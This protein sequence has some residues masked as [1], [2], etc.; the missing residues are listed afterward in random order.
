MHLTLRDDPL[1]LEGTQAVICRIKNL[2]NNAYPGFA[3]LR[4]RDRT[5]AAKVELLEEG[6]GSIVA[7]KFIRS[8]LQAATGDPI[9]VDFTDLSAAHSVDIA[10]PAQYRRDALADLIRDS[11][12]GK[13]LCV[14]QLLPVFT[15]P[16]TGD[17]Q[18]G[19]VRSIEPGPIAVVTPATELTL[20]VGSV[21]GPGVTYKNIGGLSREIEQIRE[22]VEFPFR[23][24]DIFQSLGITPS[25]G[26]ILFG[27]PGA[28]K[29][30][31]AK[32]LAHEVGASIFTIQG[33]EIISGWY[34]GSEQNLR[35]VFEQAREQA[36]AIIMIDEIDSVAPRRDKTRG[37]VEHRV[38]ATLLTLMDGMRDLSRVVV[39]GTTNSINSIDPALRRPGRF[40]HEIHIGAPDQTGRKEIL[41]IHT[42]RMPLAPDVELDRIAERC[43]GF[44]GADLAS[45]CRQAAYCALRRVHQDQLSELDTL[46]GVPDLQITGED[47]RQALKNIKPSAMRELIVQIAQDVSWASLGGLDDIKKLLTENVI[48]G[49]RSRHA[50]RIAGVK[51]A[52]GVL[53]YGPSGTGKTLLAKVIAMESGANFLA[54]RGPE[55]KSKW[56][57]ESEERVRIAFDKARESAPSIILLDELDAIA[58]PRGADPQRLG[59]SIVNQLLTEMDGLETN[60]SVYVIATTNKLSLIDQALLRPGRFDYQIF[61]PEPDQAGRA[62][63]FRVHL[64][65]KPEG[66]DLDPEVLAAKSDGMSG[67]DIAEVCRRATLSRLRDNK[68][69]AEGISLTMESLL[70]AI[71]SLKT[72]QKQKIGW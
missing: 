32:S 38:V 29:T 10:V 1:E 19:E 26:I 51:P 42:R 36:P 66:T 70:A 46:S 4:N 31:I 69:S 17:Y 41:T 65:N 53:L 22:L 7:D 48:E 6:D 24:P 18:M 62:G 43:H 63:I 15:S 37:D 23:H 9:E 11:L 14:R 59:D 61:V 28:G 21:S 47:F 71:E 55:I 8:N 44:V 12:T 40:E 60:D 34:G 35:T 16:L 5:C 27:P 56:Y 72:T 50:F 68:F 54:I 64:R 67:A 20:S 58:G 3:V 57:G 33:P 49:I 13:P 45:L 39:V 30:L 2:Q 25:R 52:Q